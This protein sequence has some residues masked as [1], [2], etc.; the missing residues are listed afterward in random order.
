TPYKCLREDWWLQD[1]AGKAELERSNATDFWVRLWASSGRRSTRI[2]VK[3]I[4]AR[5]RFDGFLQCSIRPWRCFGADFDDIG[6]LCGRNSFARSSFGI[7]A[8]R[9][10]VENRPPKPATGRRRAPFWAD[11]ARGRP[12]FGSRETS[13]IR[14]RSGP[15]LAHLS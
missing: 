8:V 5:R 6:P 13:A 11:G 3:P 4:S 2:P 7:R 1:Y 9:K 10:P 14:L 15:G 12:D